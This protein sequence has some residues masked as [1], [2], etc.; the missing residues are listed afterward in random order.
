[1]PALPGRL[2]GFRVVVTLRFGVKLAGEKDTS[3]PFE[4]NGK[5]YFLVVELPHRSRLGI[6]AGMKLIG[7]IGFSFEVTASAL[8]RMAE[9]LRQASL[10]I[11]GFRPI[12]ERERLDLYRGDWWKRSKGPPDYIA[13]LQEPEWWNTGD[14]PPEWGCAA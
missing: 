11:E 2:A 6:M 12:L 1:M 9:G 3:G 8:E 10:A 7:K 5:D 13:D 4:S 14:E